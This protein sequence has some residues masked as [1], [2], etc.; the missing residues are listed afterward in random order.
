MDKC[1]IG[2][3]LLIIGIILL[4]SAGFIYVA[5]NANAGIGP[6][7]FAFYAR[8]GIVNENNYIYGKGNSPWNVKCIDHPNYQALSDKVICTITEKP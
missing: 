2:I 3:I 4:I 7:G 6:N 1:R 5:R 8:Q